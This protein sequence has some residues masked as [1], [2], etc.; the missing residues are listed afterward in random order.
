MN[1][2][3]EGWLEFAEQFPRLRF[4]KYNMN[5]QCMPDQTKVTFVTFVED[6][7]DTQLIA[8][9]HQDYLIQGQFEMTKLMRY[10]NAFKATGNKMIAEYIFNEDHAIKD[11]YIRVDFSDE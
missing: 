3:K 1:D 4:P 9:L 6:P 10:L 5:V 2:Y 8:L 7:K 11:P